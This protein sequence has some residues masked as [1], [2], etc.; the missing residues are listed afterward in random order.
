MDAVCA[1]TTDDSS[2]TSPHFYSV[3]KHLFY[4]FVALYGGGPVLVQY[5]QYK[6]HEEVYIEC[7]SDKESYDE[8]VKESARY[9]RQ[10]TRNNY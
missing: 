8:E 3:S 10:Q 6:A 9:N 4:Y 2:S 7:R 1:I 5:A